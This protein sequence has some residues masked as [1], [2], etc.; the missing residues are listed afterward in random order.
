MIEEDKLNRL[1]EDDE[2]A[3]SFA[4]YSY[5]HSFKMIYSRIGHFT[6]APIPIL[7]GR[8]TVQ[9]G[10]QIIIILFAL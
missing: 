4:R 7:W 2:E 10:G 5:S 6:R 9:I 1:G 8:K 3:R